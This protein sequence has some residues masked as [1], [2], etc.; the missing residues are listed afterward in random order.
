LE[1]R[2]NRIESF[3]MSDLV[4][5]SVDMKAGDRHNATHGTHEPNGETIALTRSYPVRPAA[6]PVPA[7]KRSFGLANDT[8][9]S[10]SENS[11]LS[12]TSIGEKSMDFMTTD[13]QGQS[14]YIGK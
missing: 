9:T 12:T 11:V 5:E 13:N 2:L 3:V 6:T 14:Q 10:H 1:D 4:S 7:K 8:A